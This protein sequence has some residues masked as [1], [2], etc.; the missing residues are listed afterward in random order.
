[1]NGDSTQYDNKVNALKSGK[2]SVFFSISFFQ[3]QG[4]YAHLKLQLQHILIG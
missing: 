4:S 2:N 3:L 1:M